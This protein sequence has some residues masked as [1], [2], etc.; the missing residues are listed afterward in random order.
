MTDMLT[1]QLKLERIRQN[2][3]FIYGEEKAQSLINEIEKRTAL[4]EKKSGAA[5][6]VGG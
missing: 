5:K 3:T 2:L 1:T 4:Y 6:G